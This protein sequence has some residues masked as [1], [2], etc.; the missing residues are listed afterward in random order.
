MSLENGVPVTK[1][2]AG[3]HGVLPKT[4]GKQ[5]LVKAS[6][7]PKNVGCQHQSGIQYGSMSLL[8]TYGLSKHE[9]ARIAAGKFEMPWTASYM[10]AVLP[11]TIVQI[12]VESSPIERMP[13]YGCAEGRV[14]NV[15]VK[16]TKV[17]PRTDKMTWL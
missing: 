17:Q 15:P 11:Q 1:L 13:R 14:I 4:T 9:L 2:K 8:G 16:T 12:P 3:R 10:P 5:K 7:K 6:F